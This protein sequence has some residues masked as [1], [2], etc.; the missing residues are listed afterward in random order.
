MRED[1]VRVVTR[2]PPF[3]VPVDEDG[4]GA[5]AD[6]LS[7]NC[8]AVLKYL[9]I[10]S[11]STGKITKA[12]KKTSS[13]TTGTFASTSL[14]VAMPTTLDRVGNTDNTKPNPGD[15]ERDTIRDEG[16]ERNIARRGTDGCH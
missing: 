5:E 3:V 2:V 16:D 13:N 6:M 9:A 12:C 7:A 1:E 14:S 10:E 4:N 15:Y 11:C 8:F